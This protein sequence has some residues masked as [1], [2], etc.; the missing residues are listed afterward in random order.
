MAFKRVSIDMKPR[1]TKEEKTTFSSFIRTFL[2]PP[3]CLFVFPWWS[4]ERTQ[5]P[6]KAKSTHESIGIL[7]GLVE[8]ENEKIEK[9]VSFVF[10]LKEELCMGILVS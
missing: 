9:R 3:F 2:T 6:S 1:K 10:G 7:I 4:D 8:R 5:L